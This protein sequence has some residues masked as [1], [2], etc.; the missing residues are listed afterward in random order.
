MDPRLAGERASL[1]HACLALMASV[2]M[3]AW[4]PSGRAE[5]APRRG[6]PEMLAFGVGQSGVFRRQSRA[7]Y[8][9]EYR[10]RESR[11]GLHTALL[12]GWN[13]DARYLNFSLGYARMFGAHWT[14]MI[15]TG[16]GVYSHDSPADDL[17]SPLEFLSR[18]EVARV[19]R[20]ERR[21]GLR[22]AHISNAHVSPIN[23][24]NESLSLLFAF[25]VG[26]QAAR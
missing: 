17:G 7:V 9:L 10:F 6:L 16:P 1:V 15:A 18:I 3:L 11:K 14:A 24:G 5:E 21:V 8:A 19:F 2:V 13:S 25:P 12:V 22:L 26:H 4:A 20:G 23:P